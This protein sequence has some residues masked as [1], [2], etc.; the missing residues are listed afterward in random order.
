MENV[1]TGGETHGGEN[2]LARFQLCVDRPQ[3]LSDHIQTPVTIFA[4]LRDLRG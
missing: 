1:G 2:E 4:S 3:Q